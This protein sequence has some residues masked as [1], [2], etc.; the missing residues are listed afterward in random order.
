[1][2]LDP[3]LVK[4]IKRCQQS[5]AFFL[6]TFAKVKHPKL[7]ILPFKL[8]HY[9]KR[10]LKDFLRHR[11]TIF[12][13]TRQCGISTLTGGFALW[14]AM[15]FN[16][17]TILIVS[18]RDSDAMEFV[19]R[20]IK[21]VY[22]NLP[23]W[24]Q[25][26]WPAVVRNEHSIGFA[27]GSVVKSLTSSPETLRSNASSLN[28][29]D[30]AA[31]FQHMDTMWAAGWPTLQHGGSVIVI[32]T[33]NGIGNWYWK[34]WTDALA[35]ENDFHPIMVDWWDMDWKL[36]Y[37]DEL[38]GTV[39]TIAPCAGIRPCE[40]TH[41]KEKY[42]PYWSPWLE[43]QYRALASKGDDS[44]FRQ[45]VL[46]EFM[47]IGRT[48]L[49]R[50]ALNFVNGCLKHEYK[51]ISRV[52]YVNPMSGDR[53]V[54]DFQDNFWIWEPPYRGNPEAEDPAER[55]P[56]NYV[57]GADTASGEANDY[58]ALQVF[59]MVTFSQVAEL[60]VKTLPKIFARMVDYI[61]RWYN[62]AL[63]VCER[64]G[65]GQAVTQELDLDIVYPN[66]YRQ[67]RK[68]AD[69][70]FK[71]GYI[72]F[73]TTHQSKH[74][75]IKYLVDNIGVDGFQVRSSRLLKEFQI[76]VHLDGGKYGC[77]PGPGNTDDL[78][79]ATCLAF[80]G[81]VDANLIANRTLVP[82]HNVGGGLPYSEAEI[83]NRTNE[84]IAKGG[85]FLLTPVV[86]NSGMPTGKESK[87]SEVKRFMEQLGGVPLQPDGKAPIPAP[88][89]PLS[90][91]MVHAKKHELRFKGRR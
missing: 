66:L 73:Q 6:D 58:C 37:K 33:T 60:R 48:V 56:H 78:V 24:M 9:Q 10:C 25:K 45:E 12:K 3:N 23:E 40:D 8:F 83:E 30:E 27:N 88:L 7:G 36:E 91:Q 70:K 28:I 53:D 80:A 38:S 85:K 72:G 16:N 71:Q 39:T 18:K 13:K 87:T 84:L 1:M 81:M 54:L 29:I 15:F 44:R 69:L 77:E 86:R 31:F 65:I 35:K 43:A 2:P 74:I 55:A 19:N 26:L 41:E 47:G 42:G 22:D 21:F 52:D 17:K 59:D 57:I 82:L 51:T 64:N 20:N 61:G 34:T 5:P 49:N 90:Q 89:A 76:F 50:E 63:V 32:S 68:R 46:A 79:M 14:Y 75:L 62:Q 67:R 4:I 11:F